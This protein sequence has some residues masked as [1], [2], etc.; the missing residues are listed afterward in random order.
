MGRKKN[1]GEVCVCGNYCAS[2]DDEVIVVFKDK[3]KPTSVVKVTLPDPCKI[4][5]GHKVTVIAV[6]V[7]VDVQGSGPVRLLAGERAWFVW[8]GQR[9]NPRLMNGWQVSGP[10]GPTTPIPGVTIIRNFGAT[11]ATGATG[12][13]G[14]TGATGERGATG[15]T[16]TTGPN[17]AI[18][19]EQPREVETDEDISF[20]RGASDG[21]TIALPTSFVANVAGDYWSRFFVMGHNDPDGSQVL[22]CYQIYVNGSPAPFPGGGTV[23]IFCGGPAQNGEEIVTVLGET[24][25]VLQEGDVVTLRNLSTDTVLLRV[26]SE[27]NPPGATN[28]VFSIFFMRP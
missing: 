28:A 18:Y 25:L 12:D 10:L 19:S 7:D 17:G 24:E 16:G 2:P 27:D 4:K 23:P 3:C 22:L 11:G 20:D 15:A 14:A 5:C 6:D 8:T 21:I 1:H 26:S 9:T 13:T